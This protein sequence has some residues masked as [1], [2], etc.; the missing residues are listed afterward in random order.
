LPNE[1]EGSLSVDVTRYAISLVLFVTFTLLIVVFASLALGRLHKH[2]SKPV[3]VRVAA[4]R[5]GDHTAN[6]TTER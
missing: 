6:H 2:Q 3:P 5:S 1:S 4:D